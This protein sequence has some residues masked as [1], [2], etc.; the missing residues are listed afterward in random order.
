MGSNFNGYGFIRAPLVLR[1]TQEAEL[2]SPHR[3][4]QD[5]APR[6]QLPNRGAVVY[7][8]PRGVAC[9]RGPAT[10]LIRRGK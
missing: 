3:F 1:T 6:D 2:Y 8:F 7:M 9:V 10:S 5:P 4:T